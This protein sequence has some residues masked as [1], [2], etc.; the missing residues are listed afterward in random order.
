VAD[1][2]GAALVRIRVMSTLN[3]AV[4]TNK[5]QVNQLDAIGALGVLVILISVLSCQI[6]SSRYAKQRAPPQRR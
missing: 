1:G 3:M 5:E 2:T 6:V 4:S